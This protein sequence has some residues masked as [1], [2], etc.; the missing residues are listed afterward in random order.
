MVTG[1]SGSCLGDRSS[2]ADLRGGESRVKKQIHFEVP[3]GLYEDFHRLLPGRGEKKAFFLRVM[4]LAVKKGG[5]WSF[6]Q[7]VIDEV[8]EDY[9]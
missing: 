2:A 1:W 6:T 5:K 9:G 8:E 4:E 7:A 3:K